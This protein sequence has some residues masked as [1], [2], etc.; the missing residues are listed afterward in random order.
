MKRHLSF[1]FCVTF[2]ALVIVVA[3]LGS[4]TSAENEEGAPAMEREV[5]ATDRLERIHDAMS[6][7]VERG[8]IPGLV[9]LVSRKGQVHVD[10][11]GKMA[12]DGYE[13]IRRNTIFRITSMTKPITAVATMILIEEGKLALDEP[14]DKYLPELSGRKVLKRIDGP[15]DETEDA[16]RPITVRDLLTFRLG[17]G[18]LFFEPGGKFAE[19]PIFKAIN[20]L[21]IATA[22]PW[23][24]A[25]H[26][27]DEWMRRLGQLPLMHQ[28][29]ERWMYNTGFDVL[30]VLI[31][32]VSGKPLEAYFREKIFEPL[33]M[34]DT[35][36]SV[37][38][39]KLDRL[40][41]LYLRD[42][43]TGRLSKL[44]GV[45][46]SVWAQPPAFPMGAAGLVSTVDDYMAFAQML[47]NKGVHKGNRILSEASIQ[48]MTTD[49]ITPEQ[50]ANSPFFP[51][52]WDHYGWGFGVSILTTPDEAGS[53]R[54]RYGWDG[55]AGTTWFNDPNEELIGIVMTQVSIK[56]SIFK[57]FRKAVYHEP[58]KETN[59]PRESSALLPAQGVE[60]A[61]EHQ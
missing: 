48:A 37:P 55:G 46:D 7:Y 27:P 13:P 60:R 9:Y 24:M 5:R 51:G 61:I 54:G 35:G 16:K 40:P 22:P 14:V 44:D 17:H 10:A 23:P 41:V 25:R 49:Q 30:G 21:G 43:K 45:N 50:K 56:W 12:V 29:G 4:R 42:E 31:A 38:Q 26:K 52:F 8:E 53:K 1:P 2:G 39:E 19:Y 28:P 15:V 47:L 20:G 18:I 32:R 58:A 36:F 57:D 3:F 59:H 33:G 11:I 6:G 34:T